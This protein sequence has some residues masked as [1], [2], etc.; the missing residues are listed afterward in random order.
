MRY[1]NILS[2]KMPSCCLR[3][4]GLTHL[5]ALS[6]SGQPQGAASPKCP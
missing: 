2:V 6:L 3:L 4:L 1:K 5:Y